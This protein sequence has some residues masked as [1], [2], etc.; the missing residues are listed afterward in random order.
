[1]ERR[2]LITDI[3]YYCCSFVPILITKGNV[4]LLLGARE[5]LKSVLLAV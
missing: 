3:Q 2:R 5:L 1:M 4:T